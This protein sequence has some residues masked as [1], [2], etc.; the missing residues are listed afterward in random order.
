MSNSSETTPKEKLTTTTN[1]TPLERRSTHAPK[2]LLRPKKVESK[3]TTTATAKTFNNN[4]K[5]SGSDG[6]GGGDGGGGSS[7]GGVGTGVGSSGK[8]SKVVNHKK[9]PTDSAIASTTAHP[10]LPHILPHNKN[11]HTKKAPITKKPAALAEKLSKLNINEEDEE[12]LEQKK[13]TND[14][15]QRDRESVSL[16]QIEAL[17]IR[18]RPSSGRSVGSGASGGGITTSTPT[19]PDIPTNT[20]STTTTTTIP[21]AIT[22]GSGLKPITM[23]TRTGSTMSNKSLN[24]GK[25]RNEEENVNKSSMNG[26]DGGGVGE[27]LVNRKKLVKGDDSVKK[28][29]LYSKFK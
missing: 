29:H 3:I 24:G 21:T 12:T 5:G 8:V 11:A 13:T 15:E 4:N 22:F 23:I 14:T 10:R 9:A 1:S 16:T 17:N 25:A 28:V 7:S 26:V 18:R 6:G 20:S 19:K 27:T 2:I